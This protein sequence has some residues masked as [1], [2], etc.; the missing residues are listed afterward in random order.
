MI[1]VNKFILLHLEYWNDGIMGLG[2]TKKWL[3]YKNFPER[4]VNKL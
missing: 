1:F 3:I 2:K 4:E